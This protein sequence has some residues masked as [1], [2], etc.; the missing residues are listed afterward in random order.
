MIFI[1][2]VFQDKVMNSICPWRFQAIELFILSLISVRLIILRISLM[3]IDEY[4]NECPFLKSS[5]SLFC[6]FVKISVGY[7][8]GFGQTLVDQN[9][10]TRPD[11]KM[12]P[13][14]FDQLSTLV[15]P[16]ND[17][18]RPYRT[19]IDLTRPRSTFDPTFLDNRPDLTRTLTRLFP[20]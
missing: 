19:P 3:K 16:T 15:Y 20:I 14:R 8:L 2:T 11:Q 6:S 5:N 9:R 7:R 10:A 18:H 12:Q 4:R 17:D 13:T 1:S